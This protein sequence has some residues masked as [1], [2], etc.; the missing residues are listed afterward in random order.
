[1]LKNMKRFLQAWLR[2]PV[3][4]P[5]SRAAVAALASVAL[6]AL[7]AFAALPKG[8]TELEYIRSNK[9]GAMIDT[10]YYPNP[11]T[12]VRAKVELGDNG[13]RLKNI[14]SPL[15]CYEY[16]TSDATRRLGF[17]FNSSGATDYQFYFWMNYVKGYGET[18]DYTMTLDLRAALC[19]ETWTF[20]N[21]KV[22]IGWYDREIPAK[23]AT[24]TLVPL[25]LF[26]SATKA[27][28]ASAVTLA[29]VQTPMTLYSLEIYESDT[30]KAGGVNERRVHSFVPAKEDATGKVGLY[31]TVGKTFHANVNT[32]DFVAG[33]VKRYV[34]LKYVDTASGWKGSNQGPCVQTDFHL[35]SEDTVTCRFR[36]RNIPGIGTS[37]NGVT[38]NG[39][40]WCS[41][42]KSTSTMT[43]TLFRIGAK[44]R[45]DHAAAAAVTET[46]SLEAETDYEVVANP[47]HD[48]Y[49]QLAVNGTSVTFANGESAFSGLSGS[50]VQ[51][52]ASSIST[53]ALTTYGNC[54]PIRF[55]GMTV[56][57]RDGNETHRLVGATR[58][59]DGKVGILDEVTGSFFTTVGGLVLYAGEPTFEDTMHLAG[60]DAPG[61]TSFAGSAS[62]AASGW[63][64]EGTD[65][66]V[67]HAVSD[68][69]VYQV[70]EGRT[71]RTAA[72][73]ADESFAGYDL[74]LEGALSLE[75]AAGSGAKKVTVASLTGADGGA[76]RVGCAGK[77]FTLDV[78]LT[79][80]KDATFGIDLSGTDGA[81]GGRTL[82]LAGTL[83]G[84]GTLKVVP[85]A[86][87][88]G[89]SRLVLGGDAGAFTGTLAV[90]G[91]GSSPAFSLAIRGRFGGCLGVFDD[92]ALIVVDGAGLTGGRG[93]RCLA[94]SDALRTNVVFESLSMAFTREN[95]PILSFPGTETVDPSEFTVRH[96]ETA[97][98]AA[99]AFENLGTVTKDGWTTLYANFKDPTAGYVT[100][101]LVARWDGIDNAGI[102]VHDPDA[103]TWVDL[104]GGYDL[105]RLDSIEGCVGAGHWESDGFVQDSKKCSVFWCEQSDFMDLLISGRY[106]VEIYCEHDAMSVKGKDFYNNNSGYSYQDWFGFG[107]DTAANNRWLKLDIR[108]NDTDQTKETAM[109]QGLQYGTVGWPGDT[110]IVGP[111]SVTAWGRPQHAAI[112]VQDKTAILYANGTHQIHSVP[113]AQK[114]ITD[115]VFTLGGFAKGVNKTPV[116]NA[117]I[118]AVRIYDRPLTAE[119]LEANYA[120]DQARFAADGAFELDINGGFEEE[121]SITGNNGNYATAKWNLT[122]GW[123]LQKNTDAGFQ[124]PPHFFI[125][126]Y[127][128]VIQNGAEMSQTIDFP[129]TGLY[130][131]RFKYMRRKYS[132]S[133]PEHQVILSIDGDEIGSLTGNAYEMQDL[134]YTCEAWVEK[135]SHLV[136]FAGVDPKVDT[137]TAIDNVR[138]TC[139]KSV[140]TV[141]AEEISD[142][143]TTKVTV[144]SGA[145]RYRLKAAFDFANKG[146]DPAAW[147]HVY[148]VCEVG[149][150]T[151]AMKYAIP[152]ELGTDFSF[153]RFF[154]VEEGTGDVYGASEAILGKRLPKEVL[155]DAEGRLEGGVARPGFA[156]T[157]HLVIEGDYSASAVGKYVF[158]AK[159]AAG[160][161]WQDGTTDRLSFEWT[162]VQLVELPTYAT[163][164]GWTGASVSPELL[165]G[166]E[167]AFTKGGDLS[168]SEINAAGEMYKMTF[169]P[170]EFYF[171]SDTQSSE[172]RTVEWCIYD[173][174]KAFVTAVRFPNVTAGVTLKDFP[175]LI[176][177]RDG[178][179]KGFNHAKVGDADHVRFFADVLQTVELPFECES[180]NAGGESTFWVKVP[181]YSNATEIFLAW[182]NDDCEPPART[183]A[184][185]EVWGEYLGVWHFGDTQAGAKVLN[186]A[187]TGAEM[188]ATSSDTSEAA[189]GCA[190][191]VGYSHK[192]SVTAP[193]YDSKYEPGDR[194]TVS[195]WFYLPSYPGSGYTS[196]VSK[197]GW[198][199]S[200]WYIQLPNNGSQIDL[201]R[202]TSQWIVNVSGM[203][204]KWNKFT[205]T[206]D[207]TAVRLYVNGVAQG[208]QNWTGFAFPEKNITI[209]SSYGYCD[210]YRVSEGAMPADRIKEEYLQEAGR[211]VGAT[212]GLPKPTLS[213]S[214]IVYDGKMHAVQLV[215]V[216]MTDVIRSGTAVA[217]NPGEYVVKVRPN[218]GLTWEDGS[219]DTVILTWTIGEPFEDS[220]TTSEFL[221][222]LA[223]SPNRRT[224][225]PAATG[226]DIILYDN[227]DYIH[228]FTNTY[229]ASTFTLRADQEAA[230][231]LIV[232]GG[233]AGGD[234][235]GGGGGA[236]GVIHRKAVKMAM[237]SYQVYVGEGGAHGVPG[238]NGS[239]SD[240]R[241]GNASLFGTAIGGGGGGSWS[242]GDSAAI[243]SGKSG[244]SGG[245]SV[246][247][248]TGITAG[249]GTA[250]QGFAG[251]KGCNR[252]SGGGGGGAMC[253]GSAPGNHNLGGGGGSGLSVSILGY[254]QAF[255]GGGG[256]GVSDGS[257]PGIGGEGGGGKGSNNNS[258]MWATPGENG[259]GGG[260][261]GGGGNGGNTAGGRGGDGIV[262]IRVTPANAL[263]KPKFQ[264]Y[265]TAAGEAA[266][267]PTLLAGARENWTATGETNATAVGRHKF[268]VTPDEGFVWKDTQDRTALEVT[269]E[270]MPAGAVH[271]ASVNFV[272][273]TPG[274]DF[275]SMPVQIRVREGEP[276][277]FSYADCA[278]PN[279][280]RFYDADFNELP[281]EASRWDVNGDSYLWVKAPKVSQRDAV[282][283]AWFKSGSE[284]VTTDQKA[285]V[286]DDYVGVWH[287]D[288]NKVVNS[289]S[290]GSALDSAS[291]GF[292]AQ[293]E[294]AKFGSAAEA[295]ATISIPD[296]DG[297]LANCRRFVLSMWVY[298]PKFTKGNEF[299]PICKG[300]GGK[301]GWQI[302]YATNAELT[303]SHLRRYSNWV[304]MYSEANQWT[305][306]T[307]W[308]LLTVCSDGNEVRFYGNGVCYGSGKVSDYNEFAGFGGNLALG[309]FR[310]TTYYDE[311]RVA[312]DDKMSQPRLVEEVH[313]AKAGASYYTYGIEVPKLTQYGFVYDGKEHSP[314]VA[315]D[316]RIDLSGDLAAREKGE[317]SIIL[318]PQPGYTWTDGSSEPKRIYWTISEEFPES[319][320]SSDFLAS[321]ST[322]E[323]RRLSV[324]FATGGDIILVRRIDNLYECVHVFTNTTGGASFSSRL[325]LGEKEHLTVVAIGGGGAG[326]SGGWNQAGGGGGA[327]G[328]ALATPELAHNGEYEVAVGA[329][330]KVNAASGGATTFAGPGGVSIVVGG[331]AGGNQ[332][333][334]GQGG[335][336]GN[337]AGGA[338]VVVTSGNAG[339]RGGVGVSIP[340]IFFRGEETLA[341]GGGSGGGWGSSGAATHGGGRGAYNSNNINYLSQPG[342]NGLGGGGGGGSCHS[343]NA[344]IAT[345][346]C[347]YDF[348]PGGDGIVIVAYAVDTTY[349]VDAG[350]EDMPNLKVVRDL[351][352]TG[353]PVYAGDALS[354][355]NNLKIIDGAYKTD[356]GEYLMAVE[357]AD[358]YTWTDGTREVKQ[359]LWKIVTRD[360]E[361]DPEPSLEFDMCPFG[362]EP[363]EYV[364]GK[365]K[366]G[367][368]AALKVTIAKKLAG[369]GDF[370][371]EQNFKGVAALPTENATYRITYTMPASET[372]NAMVKVLYYEVYD[373]EETPKW[374]RLSLKRCDHKD[375]IGI[376]EFR[377]F[378]ANGRCVTDG[379]GE[380]AAGAEPMR[381]MAN[382]ACFAVSNEM[383]EASSLR[384]V[385][386]GDLKT[387]WRGQGVALQAGSD[388]P[389]AW[390]TI[391]LRLPPNVNPATRYSFATVDNDDGR[392]LGPTAWSLEASRNG[393]TW[394]KV[395][396]VDGAVAPGQGEWYEDK[397]PYAIERT[398]EWRQDFMS[399]EE[400]GR[401][402]TTNL[403]QVSRPGDDPAETVVTTGRCV[404]A[405]AANPTSVGGVDFASIGDYTGS[406]EN[407]NFFD[408]GARGFKATPDFAYG[409]K[410]AWK[411]EA[412][413]ASFGVGAAWNGLLDAGYV[414]GAGGW[415]VT[416]NSLHPR[417]EYVVQLFIHDGRMPKM[418]CFRKG[419]VEG[420]EAETAFEYGNPT[421]EWSR[422][423]VLTGRFVAKATHQSFR[424][425]GDVPFFN[426]IQLREVV[427]TDD[428]A[429][430]NK[431]GSD[432]D[433]D[434]SFAWSGTGRTSGGWTR[435][436]VGSSSYNDETHHVSAEYDYAVPRADSIPSVLR[437]SAATASEAFRGASLTLGGNLVLKGDSEWMGTMYKIYSKTVTIPSLTAAGGVDAGGYNIG[438]EIAVGSPGTQ[439]GLAG[440]I[441]I[442][443][444]NALAFG[445]N[446]NGGVGPMTA[447]DTRTLDVSATVSGEGRI[448][449]NGGANEVAAS[450]LTLSGD[451]S[452]FTGAISCSAVLPPMRM[453]IDIRGKFGGAI[454]AL[455]P[456]DNLFAFQ[457][458]KVNYMSIDPFTGLRV[459]TTKVTDALREATTFYSTFVDF[460]A[461]N[462]ALMTF[463]AGTKLKLDEFTVRYAR[464]ASNEG[465]VFDN[466]GVWENEDGTLTLMANFKR[467]GAKLN[468]P[469]LSQERFDWTGEEIDV[470]P[471]MIPRRGVV[472]KEGDTKAT[473]PGDY[474]FVVVPDEGWTW[475]DGTT[476]EKIVYWTIWREPV[477][478]REFADWGY[479][480]TIEK[481]GEKWIA[482]VVQYPE[483]FSLNV[484]LGVKEVEYLLV[485]GGSGGGSF[486]EGPGV[487]GNGGAI[488]TGTL[489]VWGGETF[490]GTIGEGG[491]PGLAGGATMLYKDGELLAEAA[492]G[493][494]PPAVQKAGFG[495]NGGRNGF[496]DLGGERQGAFGGDG[497]KGLTTDISG[498]TAR[499]GAGGGG[500]G[501]K[502]GEGGAGGDGGAG[503]GGSYK[504][505]IGGSA[506]GWTGAGGGGSGA[507]GALAGSGGSGAM[508]VRYLVSRSM[509]RPTG[510]TFVYDGTGHAPVPERPQFWELTGVTCATNAGTY[511][512]YVEPKPGCAWSDG[513]TDRIR[514][515]WGIRKAPNAV[516]RLEMPNWIFNPDEQE[517]VR[518]PLV[519]CDF[520]E[521]AIAYSS[522]TNGPWA[523]KCPTAVGEYW[524]RAVVEETPNYA[525]C[526]AMSKFYI[527]SR[528]EDALNDWSY[529]FVTNAVD[530]ALVDFPIAVRISSDRI[531]GFTYGRMSSE[532]G[533]DLRFTDL[534]GEGLAHEIDT[535]NFG[536][537]SLVWVKIPVLPVGGT[538]IVMRWRSNG[539]GLIAPN[540]PTEVWS[541]YIAVWHMNWEKG[542]VRD[543]TGHGFDAVSNV[544]A[545]ST[546][547]E[548]PEGPLGKTT[549]SKGG[550]LVV[551]NWEDT[552]PCGENFSF[553]TWLLAPGYEGVNNYIAMGKTPGEGGTIYQNGWYVFLGG[554]SG[555]TAYLGSDGVYGT[556]VPDVRE[557]WFHVGFSFI[558]GSWAGRYYVNGKFIR[559]DVKP[560]KPVTKDL[561]LLRSGIAGDEARLAA[562]THSGPR[563]LAEYAQM[564]GDWL[565]F[566]DAFRDGVQQNRW[567]EDPTLS[568]DRWDDPS[569]TFPGCDHD[570]MTVFEGRPLRGEVT[571]SYYAV[572]TGVYTTEMPKTVGTYE[573]VFTVDAGDDYTALE[574]R[575]DFRIVGHKPY[576]DLKGD[577][578][579]ATSSGRIL[580][581]N[582]DDDPKGPVIDQGW[583][584]TNPAAT[585]FWQT[586]REE[587][588]VA[589]VASRFNL[590]DGVESMLWARGWSKRL[591]RLVECR[592]GNTFPKDDDKSELAKSQS[593]LLHLPWSK[594]SKRITGNS[595]L[596]IRRRDVGQ[597]VMRNL[598]DAA[599]YSPC[600]EDGI[601]TV[602]FD[603]VNAW[604]VEV[605]VAGVGVEQLSAEDVTPCRLVVEISTNCVDR[606][607]RETSLPPTD[608]N[609]DEIIPAHEETTEPDPLTGAVETNFV[610]EAT[611]CCRFAKWHAVEARAYLIAGGRSSSAY[612]MRTEIPLA[613]SH[614][615]HP[616]LSPNLSPT[617]EGPAEDRMSDF[618]RIVLP[619]DYHGPIRFRIRRTATYADEMGPLADGEGTILIDNVI[620]SYPVMRT[621]LSSFGEYDRTRGGDRTL[622]QELAWNVPMP[623][624]TDTNLIARARPTHYSNAADGTSALEYVVS[625]KMNYRWRYLNQA[626]DPK[627]G[628]RYV[629]FDPVKFH[630]EDVFEA[631]EPLVHPGVQGDIEYFFTLE[632]ETPY[633][634]YVDYSGMADRDAGWV[635]IPGYT[636]E[637]QS[638]TN[639][640]GATLMESQGTD[641]FVRLREGKSAWEDVTLFV[642]ST[643][644]NGRTTREVRMTLISDNTWRGYYRTDDTNKGVISYRFEAYN[645]QTAG[646]TNRAENV[647]RWKA[648]L[649]TDESVALTTLVEAGEGDWAKLNNDSRS[650]F[651]LFQIGD[652]AASLQVVHAERQD[653]DNWTS[654]RTYDRTFVGDSQKLPGRVGVSR[655]LQSSS[656]SFADWLDMPA[657]NVH[658]RET[659]ETTNSAAFPIGVEFV[660]AETPQG[661]V[662]KNAF[663][664]AAKYGDETTGRALQL[665]GCGEGSLRYDDFA[666]MPRGLDKVSFTARVAQYTSFDTISYYDASAEVKNTMRDYVFQ[667]RVAFDD[668]SNTLWD[669]PAS[670]SLVAYYRAR[671]G[672]YEVRLEQIGAATNAFG[673]VTG[674]NEKRN[675]LSLYRWCVEPSGGVRADLLGTWTNELSRIMFTDGINGRYLPMYISVK[676]EEKATVVR[677]GIK[678]CRSN[679]DGALMNT[680]ADGM[681]GA[682]VNVCYRDVSDDRLTAGTY[683]VMSANCPAVFLKPWQFTKPLDSGTLEPG[684]FTHE[685]SLVTYPAGLHECERDIGNDEW[686]RVPGRIETFQD[687]PGHWGLCGVVLPQ[688]LTGYM[689]RRG[690]SVYEPTNNFGQLIVTGWPEIGAVNVDAFVARKYEWNVRS[691]EDCVLKFI[692]SGSI[693]KD[694][695]TD[696]IVDD[697]EFTQWR[698]S[699]WTKKTEEEMRPLIPNWQDDSPHTVLTN[700]VF[701]S[702]WIKDGGLLM[703]ARRSSP[704]EPCSVRGPLYDGYDA[705]AFTRG[706]GLGMFSF[707]YRD[708]QPNARLLLQAAETTYSTIGSDMMNTDPTGAVWKTVATFDFSRLSAAERAEGI[709]SATVGWAG[710]RGAM[711]IILDPQLVR[712]IADSAPTDPGMFGEITITGVHSRDNPQ[713]DENDWWGWNMRTYGAEQIRLA[714]EE[715]RM[716]LC[717]LSLTPSE[718]GM[719]AALNNSIHDDVNPSD[720]TSFRLHQPFVESPNAGTNMY[721]EI[722]LK[723]RLYNYE[724][725]QPA[726]VTVLGQ[727]ADDGQWHRVTAFVVSNS[728]FAT[729][730]HKTEPGDAYRAFR[731]AVTGVLG[732]NDTYTDN[733]APE[734]YDEPVRVLIDDVSVCE[735]IRPR[736]AFRNVGA[737][738]AN[739]PATLAGT[740]MV[741]GAGTIDEQPLCGEN[742]GVQCEIYPAMLPEEIDFDRRPVVWLYSYD[743]ASPWGV[744]NWLSKKRVNKGMLCAATDTNLVYRSSFRYGDESI[745]PVV[746]IPGVSMQYTLAVVWYA[747][748]SDR[749]Q[750]N[751]L[752]RSEWV[753]PEWYAPVDLNADRDFSA[754]CILDNVAPGWAWINEVNVHGYFDGYDYSDSDKQFI[755]IAHPAEVNIEGWSVNL[756]YTH[757]NLGKTVITNRIATFGDSNK[758]GLLSGEKRKGTDG[759]PLNKASNMVFRVL[760]CPLAGSTNSLLN[761][762][763]GT[764]DGTW[765]FDIESGNR[766]GTPF[767]NTADSI[768]PGPCG[769]Q[770]VRASGVIE[771]EIVFHTPGNRNWTGEDL[772]E[773][774]KEHNTGL[775]TFFYVGSDDRAEGDEPPPEGDPRWEM[776]LGVFDRRGESADVWTNSLHWTPGR[777]NEGQFIDPDHPTPNGA[778]LCIYSKIDHSVGH[779]RQTF[780]EETNTEEDVIAVIRAGTEMGTNITYRIDRWYELASVS[781]TSKGP[782]KPKSVWPV[783]GEPRTYM[784]NVGA[785]ASN[786]VTVVA[787]A[788]IADF[789]R[790]EGLTEDNPYT[791]AVMKWLSDGETMRGDFA[792]QYS[793]KIEHAEY[794]S[795]WNDD[796]LKTMSLTEMYW[797]DIDP[798][799]TGMVFKA[800]VAEPPKPEEVIVRDYKGTSSVTNL[801]IAYDMMISNSVTAEAWAPYVL[802]GLAP[803]ETSLG[804]AKSQNA[805]TGATFKVTGILANGYVREDNPDAWLPLRWFVFDGDSFV[806]DDDHPFRT[807]VEVADPHGVE[808]PGYWS[809]WREW[810]E[811]YPDC[812]VFF[813]WAIDERIKPYQIDVLRPQNRL[814]E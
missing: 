66:V 753:R 265:M 190:G 807:V 248:A 795:L 268:T 201:V 422:G 800:G 611:N 180:W 302:R 370:Q 790:D 409:K 804:A 335:S 634:L 170:K 117:K 165:S 774:L 226:G 374:F 786:S 423:C 447:G 604:A 88:D 362:G 137:S 45:L 548:G 408:A 764:Y 735:A 680:T 775:G 389:A 19:R 319:G 272:G 142:D 286:W 670:L 112:V 784:L 122:G 133:S 638:V 224:S 354:F 14:G 601:G 671:R 560:P 83:K 211:G 96:R 620:A 730:S 452:A 348:A 263:A 304:Q 349:M 140:R 715:D 754:Y 505:P 285:D 27:D 488:V 761:W 146:E 498:E 56:T 541:D 794:R 762:V 741:R 237:G 199:T 528:Y 710:T 393:I 509:E 41:R 609:A 421:N 184:A 32:D 355:T 631:S 380:V 322:N 136:K 733:R 759:E 18:S 793:D 458:L 699:H 454:E 613:V 347:D 474:N 115:G 104:V 254:I 644:A 441:E 602:Y 577:D 433:G 401:E 39:T 450:Y 539:M 705:V 812:P 489:E 187:P 617:P 274:A 747:K 157:A 219:S 43:Y 28:A 749:P 493:V 708:A 352:Y 665:A 589:G 206:C 217:T 309:L 475:Q 701:T 619:L 765:E 472:V 324:P 34:R 478:E 156:Y 119:E 681:N 432:Y 246:T 565:T 16:D 411:V 213:A 600:Y 332:P 230:E 424:I 479:M 417:A 645:R 90:D 666:M 173:P 519:S 234:G 650:G 194:F 31:D 215:G 426:A 673:E 160:Y 275:E 410:V 127:T 529:V 531:K 276:F 532:D 627:S 639:R 722:R 102:G 149:P 192:S 695:R 13:N 660:E 350:E 545:Y 312:N 87:Q 8:Y 239:D 436:R 7:S 464:I 113:D 366:Y 238:L 530:E 305:V 460:T 492:G 516:R 721:D 398:Y 71:L 103:R 538:N 767:A 576:Y 396:E 438:G 803:D 264:R 457:G 150:G 378:D 567:L 535:W 459:A 138:L 605:P 802:R 282:F 662:A 415:T 107:Y 269:W 533:S 581:M 116:R 47:G 663:P 435:G 329:G 78:Q 351:Q 100:D 456:T 461:D 579:N 327:G 558:S 387:W 240:F 737:F 651:L 281:F 120:R 612:T 17:G 61:A 209:G 37:G 704:S 148:D 445:F 494:A 210:E 72:T 36:F 221:R 228:V 434:T 405:F 178:Q 345:Q 79:V 289:A 736:F 554:Q 376:S 440:A 144:S 171:W 371:S 363:P 693:D 167:S 574:K 760:A 290:S 75:G 448:V 344:S 641:W 629:A 642:E 340:D 503:E 585:A 1:M 703:S 719:S 622:G 678:F 53:E 785:H 24:H 584:D 756:L 643:N 672:C 63:A 661:W 381:M 518:H 204:Q 121:T 425:A 596:P 251:G 729:F 667:S 357:P 52:F 177:I 70:G 763:D 592:H 659:F 418:Q 244:G 683:G 331:G 242:S 42:G 788:Q 740:T 89:P 614:P 412:G 676:T 154:L 725:A 299:A 21:G 129:Q 392:S 279:Q 26:G 385:F 487:G 162:C 684:V 486:G 249:G 110:S 664:V 258:G 325:A 694:A 655:N 731:L 22:Q 718:L 744:Q 368:E 356:I 626:T 404:F 214:H 549:V 278:S 155:A 732:V 520:G 814:S 223:E 728:T 485:G 495:G 29:P 212:F 208:S 198:Q 403:W 727:N 597:I 416:L 798:T 266:V 582:R 618:Y 633:Y 624:V 491:K 742:W 23:T 714:D 770:L 442:P 333:P 64:H 98:G 739:P 301:S 44:W 507:A 166:D 2:E 132:N 220:G 46:G 688:T 540:D 628:W 243:N 777:I 92:A 233:G 555:T 750:T 690:P 712:E 283:F 151:L 111:N 657:T 139:L 801:V 652:E 706:T 131:L 477:T 346:P 594:T 261:G 93:L 470:L 168:K 182:Y 65:E 621:D 267:S 483:S 615:L 805:W 734:G 625:A 250:G 698:G 364:L 9:N 222:K 490:T 193:D 94:V 484:P 466:L 163:R 399:I 321:I 292:S 504:K 797:L 108:N 306:A 679:E 640:A 745:M 755:E 12:W 257:I 315:F 188:D 791:D 542:F 106:T 320:Y 54:S 439:F 783:P 462:L 588:P 338:G 537:E 575:I 779:I 60:S 197:G 711:R 395:S 337:G 67:E 183:K 328:F 134:R 463:P 135:G 508:V 523:E 84:A 723:A 55:Y 691:T 799:A 297:Y 599:V 787:S 669:G 80:E 341:A 689:A 130:R 277:G 343:G 313:M 521:A 465:T 86:A 256:G 586:L 158:T 590:K 500:A 260:G 109:F 455:P 101:G 748:G 336:G 562:T 527:C 174:A 700:F 394:T 314:E 334:G 225:S 806:T 382:T 323:Y 647:T 25:H 446:G 543:S 375:D 668:A 85:P 317:Y 35:A 291:T 200:G 656:A 191:P 196:I 674:P 295:S 468:D 294:T 499:Y 400:M 752:Q 342:V 172:T 10:G 310:D 476:G 449:L 471:Y 300:V 473:R 570:P 273:A 623:G 544:G 255:G 379:I 598:P 57:D 720:S 216:G 636:E 769:V 316:S 373:P 62:G 480:N 359:Y 515:S 583:A 534:D 252:N 511:S 551:P 481:N 195:G 547:S 388:D 118:Y 280:I 593:E 245:G 635:P 607:G 743:L 153:A 82:E 561:D 339:G 51:L 185:T 556:D 91:E 367:G 271:V 3:S 524:V 365:P 11:K 427:E 33:P 686:V 811:V 702:C 141:M 402:A 707:S 189:F 287:F 808:S 789:L 568:K 270:L 40:V 293:A 360:N 757:P 469:T 181:E 6:G 114:Q 517:G 610:A 50:V 175:A 124:I 514:V 550:K 501:A 227:G 522:A 437:T 648:K 675:A 152:A 169:T 772:V 76:I 203:T 81:S 557:N 696:V 229:T 677:A 751:W 202:N 563:M 697:V 77:A 397:W 97:D 552:Y 771:H 810:F 546:I 709:C 386:D 780:G 159:P 566:G 796:L 126:Q 147:A 69:C 510:T 99:V 235:Y 253:A 716:Y 616:S 308:N 73:D 232:A 259:L 713:Y 15:G 430:W 649:D 143:E 406:F 559:G 653:F 682:Y 809:G 303:R 603:A 572:T 318:T 296:Y 128:A 444:T 383:T 95:L 792:D 59:A 68:K 781:Q 606:Y 571:I 431:L 506:A 496:G 145:G 428:P 125:G 420:C 526:S 20:Q 74:T 630:A 390:V 164:I 413:T 587:A 5:C 687:L 738:R 813:S 717:D 377:M 569:F 179:P 353:K 536:G 218:A 419:A 746:N 512:L 591:W 726:Q 326:R 768:A 4:G 407:G 608:A 564:S 637:L 369:N 176:R 384:N 578:V 429:V 284:P 358:G 414:A 231:V 288:G 497:A 105:Q 205:V 30:G 502:N 782:Y 372:E 38:G 262:I 778:S 48:N 646:A 685:Q 361:W 525:G 766:K 658:W 758:Y 330:G 247:A 123:V 443:A 513:G 236:G 580:L 467:E 692:L 654:A 482:C 241:L 453:T 553:Y 186:S 307:E 298:A 573:A 391:V 58:K 49:N 595:A 724:A 773:S 311:T 451:W 632:Q 207:G 161:V 776:A